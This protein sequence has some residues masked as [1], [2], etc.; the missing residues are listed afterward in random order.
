R[1]RSAGVRRLARPPRG[2]RRAR[3]HN[4]RRDLQ[5]GQMTI[6]ETPTISPGTLRRHLSGVPVIGPGEPGWD[7]ARQAYNLAID[8][9]PAL[10]ATPLDEDGVAAVIRFARDAGLRVAPQRTG[11]NA[12]PLGDLGDSVLLK[13]DALQGVRIHVENRRAPEAC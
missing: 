7:L 2:D 13:T 3:P 4:H 11:H 9:R 10:I 8:Q 12:A 5:E 1:R 6:V